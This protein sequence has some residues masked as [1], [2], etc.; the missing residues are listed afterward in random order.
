M[1]RLELDGRP[2]AGNTVPLERAFIK[3]RVRV[4]MGTDRR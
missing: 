1:H 4:I 2:L 3:H